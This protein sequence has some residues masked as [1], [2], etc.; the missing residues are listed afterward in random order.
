MIY[1]AHYYQ[2]DEQSVVAVKTLK[3]KKES[4]LIILC[5]EHDLSSCT[6]CV[7][8]WLTWPTCLVLYAANYSIKKYIS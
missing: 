3:G 7:F 2:R 5:L 1:K 8:V 6:K 4:N